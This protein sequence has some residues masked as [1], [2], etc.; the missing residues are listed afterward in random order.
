MKE[1]DTL[2]W[3]G[4]KRDVVGESSLKYYMVWK[5]SKAYITASIF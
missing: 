1:S 4:E 3:L 2:I 5:E